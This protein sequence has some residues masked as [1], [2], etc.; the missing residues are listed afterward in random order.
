MEGAARAASVG[1]V[2]DDQVVKPGE[3]HQDAD[4][5]DREG[6]IGAHFADIACQQEAARNNETSTN[7]KLW[8][9]AGNGLKRNVSTAFLQYMRSYDTWASF[10]L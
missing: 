9:G 10:R 4:S 7:Q 3:E 8:E 1:S 5:Q 6:S 2:G